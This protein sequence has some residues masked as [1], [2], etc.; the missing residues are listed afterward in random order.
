MQKLTGAARNSA[1]LRVST[2][3]AKALISSG[4]CESWAAYAIARESL[5]V[6]T[7]LIDGI[8]NDENDEV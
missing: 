8:Y 5:Q 2:E 3:I 7:E 4:E 6:A 1:M